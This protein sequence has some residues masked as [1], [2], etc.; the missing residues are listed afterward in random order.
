MLTRHIHFPGAFMG[1]DE[2]PMLEA[3][4]TLHDDGASHPGVVLCHSNPAA[5]GDMDTTL[6]KVIDETLAAAGFATLRY[7]S[8]G[9]GE[10]Q[11]QIS[12]VDA[13]RLVVPEGEPEMLDVGAALRFLGGQAGVNGERLGLAGHSF[14]A[15]ISLA[16]LAAHPDERAVRAVACVGLAV[17]WRDLSY[18]GG[19]SN[20]KLFVTGERDDFAPPNLLREY[21]SRLPEPANLVVLRNTGHFFEGR[22][23]DL[24]DTLTAFFRQVLT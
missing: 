22:E 18:L 8:R 14:G 23:D 15:R 5:G 4:L 6:M 24:A 12:Q 1:G 10:S 9:V 19:W 3:H 11:G 7:N 16:Y 21:V 20:P 13:K 17:A 2:A